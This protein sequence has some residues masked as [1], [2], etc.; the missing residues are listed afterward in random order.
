MTKKHSQ[1]E[2]ASQLVHRVVK[3]PI[4]YCEHCLN[5]ITRHFDT[6]SGINSLKFDIAKKKLYVE[7][8]ASKLG[9]NNLKKQLAEIGYPVSNNFWSNIRGA[10]YQYQDENIRGNATSGDGACCSNPTDIY[11]KRRR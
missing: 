3:I 8:D 2:N 5:K 1:P 9:Y 11:A 7:Y 4:L 6:L 10:L